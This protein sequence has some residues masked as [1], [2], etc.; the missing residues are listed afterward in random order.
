M[1]ERE[2]EE[3][4]DL[5]SVA[6]M[7]LDFMDGIGGIDD[8][9]IE[10]GLN[11]SVMYE[12]SND[13]V[14][15]SLSRMEQDG[16]EDVLST[17]AASMTL[18]EFKQ[19]SR[20]DFERFVGEVNAY[21][22]VEQERVPSPEREQELNHGEDT[23]NPFNE[24]NFKIQPVEN[25]GFV[26]RSDSERFGNNEIVFQGIS[27][28]E[29]LNYIAERTDNITPHYYVIKDLASWR[30]DVWEQGQ[31]PERSAVE[32][33]DTVE[34]AIAKFNEYKGMDYLKENIIN[35]DNNEPMRR[36]ALGVS[37]NPVQMAEMD[38]L[39]TEADKTL[40]LSDTIG[41]RENGYESFMTNSKFIQDLN[42]I[43]SS[44]AIDEY[45]YYR[46][47]TIEELAADRLAF[48]NENYPEETHTRE[49]AMRVAEEYV[50]RHPNYLR[51]NRVNERVAFADFTPPFLNKGESELN[52]GEYENIT[53]HIKYQEPINFNGFVVEND[54]ITFG[55]QEELSKYVNGEAAYDV[56]DNS[57][58]KRDNEILLYAEN[59]NGDV[60]WGTKEEQRETESMT[61]GG[62]DYTV[63]DK[64]QDDNASYVV[65][66][67]EADDGTWYAAKV[68]DTTEQYRGEYE[69]EFSTD[70]RREVML[71]ICTLIIF[72]RL[73][74]T[75]T[76]QNTGQTEAATFPT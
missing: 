73:L 28:D 14:V 39:H 36:L 44:I 21:N 63:I 24:T 48:L 52:H 54:T 12:P 15:V 13:N 70:K 53:L 61:Y 5:Y 49:E 66:Q 10:D 25:G 17:G 35:P 42:K 23:R 2:R 37:Y 45:S 71:R 69:Y 4:T 31:A 16:N 32:R 8:V 33:F 47:S 11:L 60:V 19:M 51:S 57:V 6:Q 38:L 29:C 27:Y 26:V 18:D 59:E 40:L 50:R 65:G 58:M 64:W 46:D 7:K 56:L 67:L 74:L 9:A 76:K 68:T 43:T 75:V 72:Q 62:F 55:S 34:E 20:A 3:D 41:E 1:E 30:S 22:M